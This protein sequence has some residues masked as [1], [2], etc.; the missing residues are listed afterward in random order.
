MNGE[1]RE[2]AAKAELRLT[3]WPSSGFKKPW[4][5]TQ[6]GQFVVFVTQ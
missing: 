6:T 4:A 2:E 5:S 1:G 3:M